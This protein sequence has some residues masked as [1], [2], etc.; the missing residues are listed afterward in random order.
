MRLYPHQQQELEATDGMTHVASI[1]GYE[2]LYEVDTNGNVYSIITTNSRRKRIL[3][4]ENK[5]GYLSVNLYKNGKQKHYYIHRL[6]AE[7]F[8][9]NPHN[10]KYVNHIDCNK[11]N[12]AVSNLEWCTQSENVAHQVKMNTHAR[13]HPTII[14]G[15]CYG[16][17][18]QASLDI[19]GNTWRFSY[20]RRKRG[21]AICHA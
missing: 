3:K 6:V 16:S 4:P 11:H 5:N 21:D 15:K 17:E 14:N 18:R 1:S 9:P 13:A 12:N 20:E 19:Y 7:A 10:L 2:G 8:I